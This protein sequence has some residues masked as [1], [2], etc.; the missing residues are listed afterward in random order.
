[1]ANYWDNPF[2]RDRNRYGATNPTTGESQDWYD[3]PAVRD[4]PDNPSARLG[5]WTRFFSEQGF[6]GETSRDRW[7]QNQLGKAEAGFDAAQLTNP[8]LTWR[9]YLNTLEGGWMDR[10]Y[11]TLT[12]QQRG[13]FVPGQ[14]RIIRNG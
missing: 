4:D 1:M 6:G 10:L 5:E 12:P 8:G 14:T 2:W 7:G 3:T 11:A 9:K 13:S